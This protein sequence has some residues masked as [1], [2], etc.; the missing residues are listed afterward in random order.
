[1]ILTSYKKIENYLESNW[2]FKNSYLH[3]FINN[4]CNNFEKK[5][6]YLLN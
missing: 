5:Y 3:E 4:T 6:K 2:S 1:M